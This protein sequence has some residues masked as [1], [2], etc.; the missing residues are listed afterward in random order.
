MSLDLWSLSRHVLAAVVVTVLLLLPVAAPAAGRSTPEDRTEY[1]YVA[2]HFVRPVGV[3]L[4][5]LVIRPVN[6]I[7]SLLVPDEKDRKP[8]CRGFRPLRACSRGR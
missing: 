3:L 7:M 6:G 2:D 1:L 5:T 4:D 8:Q